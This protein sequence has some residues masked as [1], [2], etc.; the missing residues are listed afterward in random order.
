MTCERRDGR[1]QAG[2]VLC[3]LGVVYGDIGTSPLYALR[4]CFHGAHKVDPS[5]AN[6]LG[7]LSLVFWSLILIV[8]VQYLTFVMRA[9]NRGEGGILSLLPLAVPDWKTSSKRGKKV[10]VTLGVMGAALL[11]GDGMLTPAVTVLSALEGLEV[12]TPVLKPYIVP[13]TIFVLILLFACQRFGTGKVGRAFGPVTFVWFATLAVLG[14][15]GLIQNPAVLKSINPL[16]AVDFFWR[17]GTQGFIVLGSVFLCV[18]GA[19][20]LYADMG[21]FGHKPI[22]LAWFGL[23]LP[24]LL[25]NYM[26]QGALLLEDPLAAEN[27]FYR[28]APRWALYPLVGLATAASV[29]ASQALISGAFSLTMTAIQLGYAPRLEIDHTSA[30]Q[31]G[32]IYLPRINW[33]LMCA[34]I[35]LVLGFQS[36]SALAGAYGI[37]VT[38]TMAVTTILFYFAAR[39]LWGWSALRAGL[40]CGLVLMM[41]LAFTGANLFKV[42]DGGW[43]PLVFGAIFFTL[44]STWKTGR[45][46]LGQRMR[47]GTLP[48]TDFLDDVENSKPHRVKGTAIFLSSNPDGTPMALVHNL[49][50]NQVLHEQVVILTILTAD[51]PHVPAQER[52]EVAERKLGFFRVIGRFGFMEEPD[53]PLVLELA[54]QKGLVFNPSRS[55]FFL[56]RETVIASPRPGMI[57]WRERLFSYMARNSQSATAFFRLPPN[58]VVELGMQVEI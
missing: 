33:V 55:T 34:C 25:L 35:G 5:P 26:G 19:E 54:R 48:L 17:N 20:A 28:L 41:D 44:M 8:S 30:A 39:N 18:T 13:V 3:A 49:K 58:R 52:V 57:R 22:R 32:Q 27:P 11:F 24:A 37:A 7:V 50:H 9:D 6:I 47:S 1:I 42:A 23:V 4:E 46:L 38:L 31:R 56:S 14:L 16:Y 53:V 40:H 2:L 12:A 51:A 43:F 10:L 21:H 15:A 29:V 45:V 36:S